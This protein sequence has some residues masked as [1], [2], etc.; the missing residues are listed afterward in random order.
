[1]SG[2]AVALLLVQL[3]TNEDLA[4]LTGLWPLW[5]VEEAIANLGAVAL[6]P[7][8]LY[9]SKVG[10]ELSRLVFQGQKMSPP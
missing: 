7:P 3:H 9:Y 4:P 5:D 8:A 6:Y 2:M 1:M 10:L